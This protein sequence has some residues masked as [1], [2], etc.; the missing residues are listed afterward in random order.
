LHYL[1]VD[2]LPRNCGVNVG[3]KLTFKL[4]GD[5]GPKEFQLALMPC[6]RASKRLV[7]AGAE[8]LAEEIAPVAV[9]GQRAREKAG[10][11]LDN[12]ED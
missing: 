3:S 5:K 11:T 6:R 4:F 7:D 1:I 9:Y 2:G 12:V 8:L 10:Q